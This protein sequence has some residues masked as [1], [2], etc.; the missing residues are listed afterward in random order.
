MGQ[1][2]ADLMRAAGLQPAFDEARERPFGIA[3]TFDDAI[4]RARLFALSRAAPPCAC[5]RKGCARSG[6]RCGLR[7]A[8]GCPRR[9]RDRR[10][11]WHAPA[12]CLARLAMARSFLAATRSP[13]VSLSR[14]WTMPGRATPP[15]PVELLAAMGDQRVDQRA[16]GIAGRRMDDKAR[17]LLDDD[18]VLVLVN[19]SKRDVLALRRGGLWARGWRRRRFRPV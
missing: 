13:D 10:A 7:R 18:E 15:M 16:V 19:H 1:M 3:V 12:N 17:R 14:R 9:R 2:H 5:G 8:A 4:A 6:L 11:R